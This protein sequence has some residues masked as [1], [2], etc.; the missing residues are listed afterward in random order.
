[1]RATGTILPTRKH[2]PKEL[3]VEAK[4]K[5]RGWS[6]ALQAGKI[7]STVWMD[8]KPVYSISTDI[9]ADTKTTISRKQS[10]GKHSE[11]KCPEVIKKYTQSMGG[12]DRLDQMHSYYAV[13]RKSRK[14]WRVLA[15]WAIDVCIVNSFILYNHSERRQLT[16]LQYR[17]RL[18]KALIGGW[19]QGETRRLGKGMHLPEKRLGLADCHHCSN[20]SAQRKRTMYACTTC[21]VH[22]CIDSCFSA[23]HNKGIYRRLLFTIPIF[24]REK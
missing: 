22:L 15:D 6:K 19:A 14:W 17:I 16:Q 8:K 2:F 24:V 13:G 12:V 9:N 5:E 10:D 11:V 18:A 7:V 3:Q 23:H 20:R 4:N 21:K 1:M